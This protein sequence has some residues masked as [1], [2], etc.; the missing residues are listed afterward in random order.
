MRLTRRMVREAAVVVDGVSPEE[1]A[2]S[3]VLQASTA[4]HNDDH[5]PH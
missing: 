2:A 5:H 4:Q 1:Y 3:C